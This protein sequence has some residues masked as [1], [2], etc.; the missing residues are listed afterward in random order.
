MATGDPSERVVKLASPVA[1][2]GACGLCGVAQHDDGF[3]DARLD[4]EFFG[5]FILCG[6]CVGDYARLFNYSSPEDTIRMRDSIE[7]LT[8]EVATLR[9]AVILLENAVDSLTSLSRVT[10]R[11]SSSDSEPSIDAALSA[12]SDVEVS[13][14]FVEGP[15]L[16]VNEP[17]DSGST[18]DAGLNEQVDESGRDDV[19]SV[20]DSDTDSFLADLGI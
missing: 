16:A 1:S 18:E 15:E 13:G 4:F 17:S 5:T 7:S 19:L 8:A 6:T 14:E 11:L 2:P 10:D 9:Q 20:S 12:P 3:A